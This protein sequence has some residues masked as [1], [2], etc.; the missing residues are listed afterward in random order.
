[1]PAFA[2]ILSDDEIDAVLAY[3]KSLWPEEIRKKYDEQYK[4]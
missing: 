4:K 2:D 1:M 3:I